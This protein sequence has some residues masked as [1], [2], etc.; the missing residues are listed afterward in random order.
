MRARWPVAAGMAGMAGMACSMRLGAP[1]RAG[2]KGP[3]K[4]YELR[5]IF[6]LT[7][8]CKQL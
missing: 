2:G 7:E 5:T 1:G 6:F 3:A 8:I 4:T